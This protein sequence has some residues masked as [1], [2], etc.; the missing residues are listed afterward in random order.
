MAEAAYTLEKVKIGE[1]FYALRVRVEAD[2]ITVDYNGKQVAL[3]KALKEIQ[4]GITDLKNEMIRTET[5]LKT[6]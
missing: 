4:V 1:A 3:T 5:L 2:G 6:I